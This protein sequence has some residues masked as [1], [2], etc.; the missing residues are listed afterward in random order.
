MKTKKV[1]EVSAL[2][3][4]FITF[5]DT[6]NRNKGN[7][8][9]ENLLVSMETS[10]QSLNPFYDYTRVHEV[11]NNLLNADMH[12]DYYFSSRSAVRFTAAGIIRSS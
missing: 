2:R 3:D 12:A 11:D 10:E 4:I 5:F 7:S 8:N 6:S 9:K 1:D